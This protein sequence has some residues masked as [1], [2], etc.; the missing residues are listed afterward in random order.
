MAVQTISSASVYESTSSGTTQVAEQTSQR[1]YALDLVRLVAMLFMMQGHVLNAL[2]SPEHLNIAE[3]P[4]SIWHFV[5]GLTAPIFLM[6]SGAVHVFA[7][8]RAADGTLPRHTLLRRLRWA[9]TIIGIGYLMVF[10]ASRIFDLPYVPSHVWSTFFRINI[11]QLTGAALALLTVVFSLTRST[12]TFANASIGIGL[13]ITLLSP[14]VEQVN[15]FAYVPEVI[16]SYLSYAH[17]SIFPIFPFAAYMFFGVGIGRYLQS[18]PS[19]R[20]ADVFPRFT[21]IA[22]IVLVAFSLLC[23]YVPFSL[24]PPHTYHLASPIFVCLRVGLALLCMSGIGIIYRF[25]Q[26]W[27]EYYSLFGKKALHIYVGH[28]VLLYGTPW[29]RTVGS[30]RFNTFTLVEGIAAAIGIIAVCLI[31]VYFLHYYQ[32]NSVRFKKLLPYTISA[33]LAYAL[34]V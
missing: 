25:T 19:A 13:A 6:T 10:P 22:G 15:W 2:V 28:L 33:A 18:V 12:R 16:A 32:S 7:N 31:G 1:F 9:L 8:K 29:F 3:F 23:T 21:G 17:G 4:W 26:S 24:F 5:R 11:L 20:R 34:L 30:Q 27:K 14:F